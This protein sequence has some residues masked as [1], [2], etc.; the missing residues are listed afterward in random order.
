MM[1]F[2]SKNILMP[3][4]HTMEKGLTPRDINI[5][6]SLLINS[7]QSREG[8]TKFT[9][10]F[11]LL[12]SQANNMPFNVEKV[13]IW[14]CNLLSSNSKNFDFVGQIETLSLV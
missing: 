10:P 5:E 13:S 2:K 4:Y 3:L 9:T 1:P 11:A 12:H 7:L 8:A 6:L 14:P